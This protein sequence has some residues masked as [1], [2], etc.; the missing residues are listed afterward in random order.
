MMTG[1]CDTHIHTR[2]S[3]DGKLS[4]ANIADIAVKKG[5]SY[6]CTTDHCDFDLKYGGCHAPYRKYLNLDAYYEEWRSVKSALEASGIDTLTMCFGI[7][8]GFCDSP[9]AKEAYRIAIDKYPF[10][11]VINSV[12][13]VGG[14]EAYFKSAFL[15]KSKERMYGEYLDTVL[16]SLDAPYPYEI[17]AHIGYITHGAP[18]R[19]KA[20]RYEDFPDKIDDILKGI[21]DRDKTLEINCHHE[22]NPPKDI[23]QRYYD[24]GGRRISYGGDSHKGELCAHYA[25]AAELLSEIGFTHFSV[26]KAHKEELMPIII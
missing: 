2:N 18:Y 22:M 19:D 26:F 16:R 3:H 25:E 8:A 7:E 10:D 13:C 5:I 11:A 4:I 15:F 9:A 6:I 20:L 23:L 21:I 14:K 1:F 17:V 12:H 24:L